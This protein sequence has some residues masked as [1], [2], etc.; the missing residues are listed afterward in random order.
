MTAP[1][2]KVDQFVSALREYRQ[3][4]PRDGYFSYQARF[5]ETFKVLGSHFKGGRI[6]DVGGWPGDF[7]CTLASL[8]MDV[9]LLDKDLSRAISKRQD[10]STG[11]WVLDGATTLQD[12]CR[13]YGVETVQCDIE[14]DSIPL[15]D[16]SVEF[17][18]FT[19]VIEHLR[20]GL[21]NALRELHRILKP[22]GRLL[23]STPNLLSLQNRVSFLFGRAAYDTLEMPFDALAAEERIGHG[24]HFRVFSLPEL[25]HLFEKTGFRIIASR[26]QHIPWMN[27]GMNGW[28]L[29]EFRMRVQNGIARAVPAFGNT[30]FLVVERD[31]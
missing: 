30:I 13:E 8:N 26:R 25:K 3:R 6:V 22:G 9:T 28:S 12:R 2:P 29:Y 15:E 4:W 1:I 23:V 19:E 10:A 21:L 5:V 14:R 24:G 16:S 11:E 27:D 17:I 7:S 31:T 20:I 18:V